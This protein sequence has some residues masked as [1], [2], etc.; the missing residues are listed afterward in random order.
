MIQN[1]KNRLEK[2]QE[3]AKPSK[4]DCAIFI[5]HADGT[6]TKGDETFTQQEFEQFSD[7]HSEINC[8]ENDP[9]LVVLH[10]HDT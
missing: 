5:R 9:A 6:Y 1:L 8:D 4:L 2:I 3:R 7:Y 10:C